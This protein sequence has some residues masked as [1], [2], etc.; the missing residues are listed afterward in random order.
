LFNVYLY[1]HSQF[2]SAAKGDLISGLKMAEYFDKVNPLLIHRSAALDIDPFD[3]RSGSDAG[4]FKRW[5]E[6]CQPQPR[7]LLKHNI[8]ASLRA[9]I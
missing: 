5:S 6:D 7:N 2:I 8:G 4:H 1:S 3:S 9:V